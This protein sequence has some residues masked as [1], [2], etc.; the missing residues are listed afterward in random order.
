MSQMAEHKK[1][2]NERTAELVQLLSELG[3]DIPEISRK[4][5]QFKESVRYRYKEKILNQGFAISAAVDHEK[6]GLKRLIAV[7]DFASEY[8]D[9]SQAILAA[10][11][12]LCYLVGFSRTLPNDHYLANF[13]VPTNLTAEL[14]DFLNGLRSKGMLTRLEIMEFDWFRRV[15]MRPEHYNFNTGLWDFEW[16]NPPSADFGAATYAPSVP[17]KFDATDLEVIKELQIDA[18][19]S[20][21]EISEQLHVNYKKL[22][23]H[24]SNHVV[25]RRLLRGYAIN[26]MGTTYDMRIERARHR[27][28]RYFAAHLLT[29]NVTELERISLRQAANRLPFLWSEAVGSNY[30]A[31][32]AFPLDFVVEGFQYLTKAVS[33]V[34]ERTEVFAIDQ[35]ASMAFTLP[36]KLFD[37]SQRKWVFNRGDVENRFDELILQIKKSPS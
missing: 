13:S 24:F 10:M 25:A 9:Y 19:K 34:R 33:E 31:E 29:R 22:A 2:T 37:E 35:T 15:P 3:P 20:L 28:H 7:M 8:Q 27:K 18:N 1:D 36:Y 5:G 32:F 23:W 17:T 21:K 12:D 4:L 26:W 14:K 6:L 30:S 11:T 16:T